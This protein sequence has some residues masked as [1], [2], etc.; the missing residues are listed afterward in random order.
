M[1]TA[2]IL[3]ILLASVLAWAGCL[4]LAGPN[5]IREEFKAWGYSDRLRILVG[6]LEW[7]SA[8]ALL[9][10]SLRLIGCA[11]A[12]TIMLG[13]LVTLFRQRVFMRIEYPLVL[14]ALLLL[15]ARG[16]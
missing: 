16:R 13:V 11:I 2:D 7:I 1:A 15:V 14:L 8:A 12:I 10:E 6:V 4:N 5:F 3:S 9:I